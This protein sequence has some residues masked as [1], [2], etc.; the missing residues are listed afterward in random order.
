MPW[1]E[2][3]VLGMRVEVGVRGLARKISREDMT[4]Q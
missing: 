4:D 1:V 2:I 3:S